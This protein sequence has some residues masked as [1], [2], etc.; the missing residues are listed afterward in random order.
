MRNHRL[1]LGATLCATLTLQAQSRQVEW[2]VYGG[3]S[4][5]SNYSPLDDITPRNVQGMK[6]VWQ[7]QHGEKPNDEYGTVPFRFR[8][9]VVVGEPTAK[10]SGLSDVNQRPMTWPHLLGKDVIPGLVQELGAERVDPVLVL[11]ARV[12]GPINGRS[13]HDVL[14][15]GFDRGE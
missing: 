15:L 7:W 10:V 3:D 1:L 2:A 9:L 13:G 12:A 14:L 11:S 8:L 4:T 5:G 6:I